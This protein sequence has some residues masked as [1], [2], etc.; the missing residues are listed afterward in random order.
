M[1]P[2]TVARGPKKRTTRRQTFVEP[3]TNRKN[4]GHKPPGTI[5]GSSTKLPAFPSPGQG[6]GG[7]ADE[8]RQAVAY[9]AVAVWGLFGGLNLG[10]GRSDTRTRLHIL[11]MVGT[12]L[13]ELIPNRSFL[14]IRALFR[15]L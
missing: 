9:P 8:L 4:I 7:L 5:A 11:Q 1:A 6:L 12:L 2:E 3:Q 10:S 13:E 15:G 14:L